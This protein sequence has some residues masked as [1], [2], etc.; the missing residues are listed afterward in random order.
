M[1]AFHHEH[2]EATL[3]ADVPANVRLGKHISR[4]SILRE[5]VASNGGD[6]AG[7]LKMKRFIRAAQRIMFDGEH[8]LSVFCMSHRAAAAWDGECL[9]LR[10]QNLHLNLVEAQ[11]PGICPPPQLARHY[12]V[13]VLGTEGHNAVQLLHLFEDIAQ[14]PVLDVRHPGLGVCRQRTTISGQ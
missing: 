12:A 6:E 5:L 2:V 11:V 1:L 3:I 10:G 7:R 13:R 9:R 14:M 4:Q 8:T